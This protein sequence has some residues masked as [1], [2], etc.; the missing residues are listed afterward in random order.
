MGSI[1][2]AFITGFTAFAATNIDDLVI[3]MVFFSQINDRFRPRHI[4]IGQYVGF[5]ALLLAC[6]PGF[7]SGLFI[8]KAWI[9]WL[10]LVP[11]AIGLKH[12]WDGNEDTPSIQMVSQETKVDRSSPENLFQRTSQLNSQ[13]YHVAAVTFANGGDNIGIYVPLFAS[14]NLLS[15]VIILGVFLGLVAVWCWVAYFLTK[16]SA[17]APLLSRYAHRI[18]PFVLVGL[19]LYI[20]IES[21][22]Y[23]LLPVFST[24]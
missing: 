3:L 13:I 10:G 17:I 9:G 5:V 12:L 4:V 8:P 7:F 15:L 2:S 24:L 14:S 18:V 21:G 23:R 1:F 20:L 19:G 6:L 11:I 22:A 16:H